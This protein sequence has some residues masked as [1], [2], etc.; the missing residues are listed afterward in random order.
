MLKHLFVGG[1]NLSHPELLV[2]TLT[3]GVDGMRAEY[4]HQRS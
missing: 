1:C 2:Y 3:H 4:E